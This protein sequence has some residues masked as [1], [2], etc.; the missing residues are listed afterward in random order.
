MDTINWIFFITLFLQILTAI[1]YV[2]DDIVFQQGVFCLFV[3]KAMTIRRRGGITEW[4]TSGFTL[5]LVIITQP[6]SW[7]SF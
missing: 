2:A 5:Y 7:Y 4:A 6:E 1:K 3:N